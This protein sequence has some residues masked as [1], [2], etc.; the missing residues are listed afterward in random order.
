V[1]N[2]LLKTIV[3]I[4]ALALASVAIF[5]AWVFSQ[6]FKPIMLTA[7]DLAPKRGSIRV[8]TV[9]D[10]SDLRRAYQRLTGSRHVF[11][12]RP[13]RNAGALSSDEIAIYKAVLL[14][15]VA[16]DRTPLNVALQTYPLEP[17]PEAGST[18]C[19]CLRNIDAQTLAAASRSFHILSREILPRKKARLVDPDDY[20]MA[21]SSKDDGSPRGANPSDLAMADVANG[22]FSMSEIAFDREHRRALVS[23]SFACGLLCGSGLTIVFEKID[24]EWRSTKIECGGWA[25]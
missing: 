3:I 10:C 21:P 19:E 12:K 4:G 22:V 18:P 1:S 2:P 23:Y 16:G 24:G 9:E 15:W 14:Q 6:R 17:F 8:P 25:S 5:G 20:S 11:D 7:A 13:P